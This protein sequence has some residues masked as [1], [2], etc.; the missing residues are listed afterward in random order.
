MIIVASEDHYK[1]ELTLHEYK[2]GKSARVEGGFLI[3]RDYENKELA[4]FKE[5][6]YVEKK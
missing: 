4:M 2:N 3:I 5:W 1:K 6:T